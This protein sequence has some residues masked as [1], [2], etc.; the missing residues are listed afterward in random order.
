AAPRFT[1][2]WWIILCL[3]G[4]DY[5]STL[6]YLPSIAVAQVGAL[7]P[8]A[9]VGVALITLLAALPVYWYVVGRAPDGLGAP[10][11]LEKRLHGWGGKLLILVLLGFV[12]ADFV[13]TRTL[14]VSDAS[15]H[16]LANPIWKDHSQWVTD[17]QNKL[18][19]ALPR[20]LQGK[21]FDFWNEQL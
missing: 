20:V 9:A 3:V 17:N 4:L 15:T 2:P 12:A 16:L 14:S 21:F 5:F 1:Y 19:E 7:A 11:L 18:R 8:V 13:I 6:A 10:G